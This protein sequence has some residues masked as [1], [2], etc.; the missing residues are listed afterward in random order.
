MGLEVC[1]QVRLVRVYC[2]LADCS[3]ALFPHVST[4]LRV[5][6]TSSV[7]GEVLI[8]FIFLNLLDLLAKKFPRTQESQFFL[9]SFA[10]LQ[11]MT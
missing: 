7:A 10:S 11:T 8:N 5:Y 4:F 1:S 6:R 3:R 2:F 9:K